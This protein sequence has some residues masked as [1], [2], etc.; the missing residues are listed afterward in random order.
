MM[1]SIPRSWSR[2]PGTEHRPS[3]RLTLIAA[4]AAS[5]PPVDL[6]EGLRRMSRMLSREVLDPLSASIQKAERRW[7]ALGESARLPFDPTDPSEL[8]PALA[9]FENAMP[10][11]GS[12]E[13]DGMLGDQNSRGPAWLVAALPAGGPD[14]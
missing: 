9:R 7:N 4:R 8:K 13:I 11:P 14:A 2:R 5:L 10:T 6:Y 3:S 1:A 12:N